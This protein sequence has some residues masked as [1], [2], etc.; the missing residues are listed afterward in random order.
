M[1]DQGNFVCQ[2]FKRATPARSAVNSGHKFGRP[3]R[4]PTKNLSHTSA[5]V[6]SIG[7]RA[8][9]R[10]L[11]VGVLQPEELQLRGQMSRLL[12][13]FCQTESQAIG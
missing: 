8:K 2:A 12:Q 9:D 5:P 11:T 7:G 13:T 1:L 3:G 10:G 6:E 4:T